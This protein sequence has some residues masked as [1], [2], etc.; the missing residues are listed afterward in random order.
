MGDCVMKID[1]MTLFPESLGNVLGESIIGRAAKKGILEISCRQ[2]RDFTDNKQKQVDDYPYGGGWGCVMMAQPLAA[3]LEDI[4]KNAPERERRRVIY[5]SPQGRPFDQAT[6]RRLARDYDRLVLVCGHYE[7]IDERFIEE[8]VDEEVSLGDFV[9]T[10]GEIPALAVADAVC[11]LVPGVLS[12]EE[13]YTGE[14]HWAGL[15]EY[16]QYTRPEE[17]RGR[18]VPEILQSG[19]HEAV[20]RW[21]RRESIRRTRVRRPDMFE[22]LHL[23]EKDDLKIVSELELEENPPE[24]RPVFDARRME[25]PDIARVIEI[26]SSARL[27]QR[28][29]GIDQWE[30]G[31]PSKANVQGDI[32]SGSGWVFTHEGNIV[33]VISVVRGEEAVY[34]RIIGGSWLTDGEP[35][36]TVHRVAVHRDWLGTSLATEML[37]FAEDLARGYGVASLRADTHERNTPM[38][39]LLH[40]RGYSERGLIFI[41][42][43]LLPVV[44]EK[45]L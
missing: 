8:C 7:G 5:M 32:D 37:D 4:V 30:E 1:I 18:R 40:S 9:M 6:A 2:I 14:S 44:F 43:G 22:K 16:P 39:R 42:S 38:I 25:S 28:K 23:T 45:L 26:F 35:Y 21:R 20:A 24:I 29:R 27:L 41:K 33:G 12:D 19:D 36:A 11:R 13:C 3:C 31:Y 15:L 34:E 17:W 10:G